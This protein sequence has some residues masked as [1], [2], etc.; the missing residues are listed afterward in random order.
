MRHATGILLD[1][2]VER[3]HALEVNFKAMEV[4]STPGLDAVDICLVPGPVIPQMF[5]VPDFD[6]Y[7]GVRYPCTHLKAYYYK[8]E[9]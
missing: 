2:A 6:K 1:P 8:M 4:H 7:K 9:A 3:V 5:K